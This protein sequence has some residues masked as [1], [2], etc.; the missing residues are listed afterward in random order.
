ML[1]GI[2]GFDKLCDDCKKEGSL[3]I[4]LAEDVLG[5][6]F[7]FCGDCVLCEGIAPNGDVDGFV[8]VV[9]PDDFKGG[10]Q[11]FIE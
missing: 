2:E 4:V 10:E 1:I 11:L 5:V 9:D 6:V 8:E 7:P 3:L